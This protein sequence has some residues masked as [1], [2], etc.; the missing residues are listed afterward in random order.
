MS[1]FEQTLIATGFGVVLG[2]VLSSFSQVVSF[3]S[4]RR[5]LYR[6]FVKNFLETSTYKVFS[7]INTST[8]LE[9]AINEL[10]KSY[11]STRKYIEFLGTYF[12]IKQIS[13]NLGILFENI[14]K[15][16][17]ISETISLGGPTTFNTYHQKIIDTYEETIKSFVKYVDFTLIKIKKR[18]FPIK[19][20]FMKYPE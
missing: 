12:N 3:F 20:F 6:S 5:D 16:V 2:F 1:N 8:D 14:N 10:F 11:G 17:D 19:N 18:G 9:E 13:I 15:L 7:N 4:R